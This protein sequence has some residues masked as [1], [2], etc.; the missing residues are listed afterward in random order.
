MNNKFLKIVKDWVLPVVIAI[1]VALLMKKFVLYT[2]YI[3]SESMVPTLNVDDRLIVT[4]V[5]NVD[6]LK[7]G[8]IIVFESKEFNDTFIKRLIGLPGDE[9][10]ISN[11]EVSVNGEKIQED[12]V[13]NNDLDYKGSFKV[14]DGKYFFLGDNRSNSMDSRYWSNPYISGKYIQ[15]KA[16][17]KIYP[18][19]DL[20]ILK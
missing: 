14:P 4:K 8:D 10:K 6:K 18:F 2:V 16:Q 7:R 9:I 20:G 19:S 12:Y 13:K 17:F 5:H 1:I 11:G 15:G 3:P